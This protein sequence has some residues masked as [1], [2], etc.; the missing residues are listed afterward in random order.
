MT[1][2][3]VLVLAGT[4]ALNASAVA[5]TRGAQAPSDPR[6][7]LLEQQLRSVQQQLADIKARQDTTDSSAALA[8]RRLQ[9]H[10]RAM[11]PPA[12]G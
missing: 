3:L 4:V 9:P 2:G 5:Q 12:G 8:C 1:K 7:G 11:C 10:R 6:I